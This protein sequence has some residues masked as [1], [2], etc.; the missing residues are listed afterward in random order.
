M[1]YALV[2]ARANGD[3]NRRIDLP[4]LAGAGRVCVLTDQPDFIA[5]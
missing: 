1:A 2:D 4:R 5:P 3:V